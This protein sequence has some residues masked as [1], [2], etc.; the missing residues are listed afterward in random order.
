MIIRRN[1]LKKRIMVLIL[2]LSIPVMANHSWDRGPYLK[3]LGFSLDSR[4]IA[5]QI[6]GSTEGIG[7]TTPST[8]YVTDLK[9]NRVIRKTVTG[10]NCYLKNP[11]LKED[12]PEGPEKM[13]KINSRL[14]TK[15]MEYLK[16]MNFKFGVAG[17]NLPASLSSA[18]NVQKKDGAY[19]VGF[20][21]KD[22]ASGKSYLIKSANSNPSFSVENK[23]RI[24]EIF[25][26]PDGRH[27]FLTFQRLPFME[28][29][30]GEVTLAPVT[31]ERMSYI[32]NSSGH[33]FYKKKKY[34]QALRLFI[35][36]VFFNRHNYTAVYN[37]ACMCGIKG[38]AADAV[39]YLEILKDS[40][41]RQAAI[42][43]EKVKTDRD[44]DNIR[45]TVNFI[46]FMKTVK[47]K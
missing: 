8:I 36:A 11:Y 13:E 7:G 47:V 5:V 3:I 10:Y 41:G 35:K 46:S 2:F 22:R 9:N 18:V 15:E 39:K 26:S 44:F 28:Y 19:S 14:K 45:N 16:N 21:I 40:N 27:Y 25:C 30:P 37:A 24:S 33:N 12:D 38:K 1:S 43:L 29:D 6:N 42:Y 31:P 17:V 23:F 32:L 34:T 20:Y 4:Y